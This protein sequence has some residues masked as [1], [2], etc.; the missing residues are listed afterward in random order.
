MAAGLHVPVIPFVDV[1]GNAG[2]VLFWQSGDIGVNA[3]IICGF[4]VTF[5]VAEVAH[6]PAVG[7]NV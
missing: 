5:S 1:D 7:V 2:A 3:G 6:C 4:T